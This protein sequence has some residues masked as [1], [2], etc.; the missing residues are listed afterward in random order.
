MLMIEMTASGQY[1]TKPLLKHHCVSISE[2]S[3]LDD[4]KL[5][6]VFTFLSSLTSN[7]CR[8]DNNNTSESKQHIHGHKLK[9]KTGRADGSL[10]D[11]SE[12]LSDSSVS[13]GKSRKVSL[14]CLVIFVF[15]QCFKFYSA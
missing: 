5:Q 3:C 12:Y 7:S 10:H 2:L 1:Y 15:V 6:K 14:L 8:H 4:D 11:G 13:C 9:H